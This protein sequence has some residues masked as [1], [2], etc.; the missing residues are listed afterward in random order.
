M[1]INTSKDLYSTVKLC[2]VRIRP[3]HQLLFETPTAQKNYFS[4][5]VM[6]TMDIA[7]YVTRS[8]NMRVRGT[9][10]EIALANYGYYTNYANGTSKTYYFW[11]LQ[12]N[13]VGK[14][15]VELTIQVDVIQTWMFDWTLQECMIE[16]CHVA[17]DTIGKWTYPE[18]FELGDYVTREENTVDGL[19][20]IVYVIATS[21]FDSSYGG[22]CGALYSG[23]HFICYNNTLT[24][25]RALTSAINSYA[26]A[27]KEDG[28]AFIFSFPKSLLPID[29]EDSVEV[30]G[31]SF[32]L[33]E[34][35]TNPTMITNFSFGDTTYTPKNNKLLTYPFNFL[36]IQNPNGSNVILKYELFTDSTNKFKLETVFNQ[37]PTITLTPEN[38]NGQTMA[39]QDSIDLQGFGLCSWN[40]DNY[41]NWLAS[42]QNSRQAQSTNA[43]NS[44]KANA[45]ATQNSYNT[46]MENMSI[47]RTQDMMNSS[48]GAISSALS[49]NVGGVI[50]SA[51]GLANGEMNRLQA[52]NTANTDLS[53]SNL[54]NTTNYQNTMRS[55]LATVQDASV[56]PNT[57]KGDTT[58]NALDLTRGSNTF[59]LKQTMI[60]P[61]YAKI[62]DNYFSM[63]GYAFNRI[64][65]PDY[66]M[67]TR[68]LWNYIKTVNCIATGNIPQDD[69][70]EIENIFNNGLTFWHNETKMFNYGLDNTIS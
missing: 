49:L 56:Q 68:T 16:R 63:F 20:E 60:K 15:T 14:N 5:K 29:M 1:G 36:T 65:S 31:F 21:D 4:S 46:N 51:Q 25:E 67:R 18:S 33:E 50:S 22:R 10:E 40:N 47:G 30:S 38:Y 27:G 69:I 59:F 45:Q 70:N 11:I 7:K 24:G 52:S 26:D 28:I 23:L 43:T 17:D 53:N 6:R 12:K 3:T 57:C 64:D 44:Y 9:V 37:N 32:V 55:L 42:T 2:N 19:D 35:Y 8:S 61:E 66:Y 13:Q 54:L 39:Y 41:S 62:I 34:E 48:L 58:A